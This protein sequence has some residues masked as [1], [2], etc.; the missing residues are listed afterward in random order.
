[1]ECTVTYPETM[2]MRETPTWASVG[3]V[4]LRYRLA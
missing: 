4:L 2:T 3:W 1:M